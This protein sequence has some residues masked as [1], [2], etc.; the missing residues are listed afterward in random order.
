[1]ILISTY[2]TQNAFAFELTYIFCHLA[3]KLSVLMLYSR[4][5]T[6]R[7][8][9]LRFAIYGI[10]IYV[11][12][13]AI[14]T[15]FVV[16][17]QCHPIH[18]SWDLPRGLIQGECIN[19]VGGFIGTGVTNTISDIAIMILPMPIVWRLQIPRRQKIIISGI[20]LLGT[21]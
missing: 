19:L 2:F 1:M 4:L 20:F 8:R 21:L 11:I 12:A 17:F 16:L 13:W 18:Y 6:T 5:F 9:P 3:L 7:Q 14:Y 15:F 10:G